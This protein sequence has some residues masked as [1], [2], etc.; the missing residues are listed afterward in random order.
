M[1]AHKPTKSKSVDNKYP[2]YDPAAI[3]ASDK[4]DEE[5]HDRLVSLCRSVA[6]L[7]DAGLD[8]FAKSAIREARKLSKEL[9]R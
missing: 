2:G 5:L 6:V 9:A 7:D 4:R 1:S 3:Y 8:V